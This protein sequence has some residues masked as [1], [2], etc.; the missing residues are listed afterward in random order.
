MPNSTG[1]LTTPVNPEKKKTPEYHHVNLHFT[2]K[3]PQ[4]EVA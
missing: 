2:D 1:A 3:S 4:T